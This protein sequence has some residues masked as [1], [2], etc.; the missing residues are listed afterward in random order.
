MKKV[1]KKENFGAIIGVL[2]SVGRTDLV[3]VM[4]HEIDLI[5]KKA[6]SGKMTKT[7]EANVAIKAKIVETLTAL[8]KAVSITEMLN[9]SAEL[10]EM[11]GGSNQ[12]ASALVT[13]LK[14]E[15]VVIRHQE[16]KKATFTVAEDL[17]TAEV[18][19]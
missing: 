2:E 18:E 16:G 12:K 10:T 4:Q 9:A 6:Q 3:A 19:K 5:D 11:V 7:Q 17:D 8:G 1:T 13:Q 14:N 15:G